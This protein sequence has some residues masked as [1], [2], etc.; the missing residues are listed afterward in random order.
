MNIKHHCMNMSRT[1]T[2]TNYY[3]QM[4]NEIT[5]T[6]VYHNCLHLT[7]IRYITKQ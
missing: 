7:Y 5:I 4:Y 1:N 2:N 3:I 6:T